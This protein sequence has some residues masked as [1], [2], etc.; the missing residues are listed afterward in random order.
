MPILTEGQWQAPFWGAKT[1]YIGG[2]DMLGMQNTSISTYGVLVPGLTN[3][4]RRIRYFG[5][6]T[7]VLELYAKNKNEESVTEFFKFVRR[8]E[9]L[10]AY[11][12]VDQ[13]P[14]TLHVVGKKFA[15]DNI[16]K[17][18][19]IIDIRNG[20]DRED[21]KITYW[22]YSSGAFGQ[23]YQ[24]TLKSVGLICPQKKC[25]RISVA[26]PDKGRNL[27]RNF[28]DSI[29]KEHKE[30]FLNAVKSGEINR[31]EIPNIAG[32]FNLTNIPED[33]DE[34]RFYRNLILESDPDTGK[35]SN[36]GSKKFRNETIKLYL[37]CLDEEQNFIDHSDFWNTF[38]G[39]HWKDHKLKDLECIRGWQY[40]CLNERTHFCL[41]TLLLHL[42]YT[43]K[44]KPLEI[45]DALEQLASEIIKKL[46]ENFEFNHVEPCLLQELIDHP[47]DCETN[48]F[49]EIMS[50]TN[51]SENEISN[52]ATKALIV[53]VKIYSHIREQIDELVAYTFKYNMRREEDCLSTYQWIGNQ[54]EQELNVFLKK[55]YLEKIINRHIEVA[56][57]KMR[58]RNENSSKFLLEDNQLFHVDNV[59]PRLTT[60]RIPALHIILTDLGYLKN[61]SE[62]TCEGKQ[63]LNGEK[64]E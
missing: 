12:M 18:P 3:L 58:N 23:Y 7:W 17:F 10:L 59:P 32:E 38:Y 46:N 64:D 9:L 31:N 26:T 6:Y 5:F 22:K 29:S 56:L 40:Y 36:S 44:Q 35:Q 48:I 1:R 19:A 60:P 37:S 57:R 53:L 28:D 13:F 61:N 63:L 51:F 33:S 21:G 55:L 39:S 11:M 27:S 8:A 20:A 14:E 41:E 47:T 4:T 54:L 15:S 24:S 2:L 34:M 62:L 42:L 49:L 52:C 16:E 25:P 30:I 50:N 45:D 43:L